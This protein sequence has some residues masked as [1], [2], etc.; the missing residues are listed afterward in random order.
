MHE[1]LEDELCSYYIFFRN[2]LY[3]ATHK[4]RTQNTKFSCFSSMSY[5]FNFFLQTGQ[6]ILMLTNWTHNKIASILQSPMFI[7]EFSTK[8][9]MLRKMSK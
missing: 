8:K 6:K 3:K 1:A 9:R 4:P 2:P 7:F 5:F